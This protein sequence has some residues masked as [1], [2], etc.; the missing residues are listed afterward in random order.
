MKA[1]IINL[2]VNVIDIMG[3]MKATL[4]LF[5]SLTNFTCTKFD[6][7]CG[8]IVFTISFLH[9]QS[10]SELHIIV[11]YLSKLVFD[12]W[13]FPLFQILIRWLQIHGKINVYNEKDWKKG[14]EFRCKPNCCQGLWQNASWLLDMGGMGYWW[15]KMDMEKA[16]EENWFYKGQVYA[17]IS[18]KNFVYKLFANWWH[19]HFSINVK[20]CRVWM[21]WGILKLQLQH[22]FTFCLNFFSLSTHSSLVFLTL[23]HFSLLISIFFII[24]ASCI[25]ANV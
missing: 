2:D 11:G 3:T 19:M 16:N 13:N 25:W 9:V 15:S 21:G 22:F 4:T 23:V 24:S 1:S 20:P 8:S 12:I 18:N 7:L 10:I 14:I 5:N 17:H 6:E